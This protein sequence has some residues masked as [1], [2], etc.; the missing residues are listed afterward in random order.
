M[1]PLRIAATWSL[2]ENPRPT[3]QELINAAAA[4]GT[5][6]ALT[7]LIR[8]IRYSDS[9]Y[10]GNYPGLSREVAMRFTT[11]LGLKVQ[12]LLSDPSIILFNRWQLLFAVKLVCIYGTAEPS[13]SDGRVPPDALLELLL[14]IND[15]IDKDD[16]SVA[17]E[18]DISTSSASVWQTILKEH[19][20]FSGE[21]PQNL[22]GRYY[23]IAFERQSPA[24]N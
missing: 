1:I 9:I 2:L 5:L 20:L 23:N 4:V 3:A 21:Q 24:Q 13:Y 8:F 22:V 12:R 18:G 17:R 14:K 11:R 16:V 19:V 7:V 15:F 6:D 10:G